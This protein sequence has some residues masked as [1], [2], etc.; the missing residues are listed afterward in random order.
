MMAST[1]GGWWGREWI[2]SLGT[3]LKESSLGQRASI[4]RQEVEAG[5]L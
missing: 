1:G 4:G 2:G 5:G 3:K